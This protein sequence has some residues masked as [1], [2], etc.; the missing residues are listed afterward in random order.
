MVE[1]EG[2][3][4]SFAQQGWAVVVDDVDGDEASIVVQCHRERCYPVDVDVVTG[5]GR[6]LCCG[7]LQCCPGE[8][9]CPKNVTRQ[10]CV[11]RSR[12]EG[13]PEVLALNADGDRK[14]GLYSLWSVGSMKGVDVT[15]SCC[16]VGRSRALLIGVGVVNVV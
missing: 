12:V 2:G 6:E 5:V 1:P 9:Q 11:V 10:H 14:V 15:R 7:G 8:P 13:Q 3:D 4:P 16:I